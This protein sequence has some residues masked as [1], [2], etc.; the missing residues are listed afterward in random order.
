MRNKMKGL[1]TKNI[2][3]YNKKMLENEYKTINRNLFMF[4]H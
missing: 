2:N 1:D 3:S 4:E